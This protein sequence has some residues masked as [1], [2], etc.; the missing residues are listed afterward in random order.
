VAEVDEV[1][2]KW[3]GGFAGEELARQ[4]GGD[5]P[6]LSAYRDTPGVGDLEEAID[7]LVLA[8]GGNVYRT[9][10]TD[11]AADAHLTVAC[12]HFQLRR[13]ALS[14]VQNAVVW[15]F[16]SLLAD[17]GFVSGGN[18]FRTL[19]KATTW[20]SPE[21]RDAVEFVV[22]NMR[23]GVSTTRDDLV[24]FNIDVQNLIEKGVLREKGDTLTVSM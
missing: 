11:A 2:E 15:A 12:V 24:P 10:R 23:R 21:Q 8:L 9:P 7:N 19:I 3:E 18:F 1:S 17:P 5:I 13:S 16:M 14:F 20:M 6:D 22:T 4:A